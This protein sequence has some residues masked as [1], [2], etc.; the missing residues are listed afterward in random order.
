MATTIA[1]M[2]PG[3]TLGVPNSYLV[4][5]VIR[6]W[7]SNTVRTGAFHHISVTPPRRWPM[8]HMVVGGVVDDAALT[9]TRCSRMSLQHRPPEIYPP[10][11]IGSIPT[12]QLK[13]LAHLTPCV[14][15]NPQDRFA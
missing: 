7:M 10:D 8:T 9:L 14:V 2:R 5:K 4:G 12:P 1:P 11:R 6:V 15:P 3:C 13:L